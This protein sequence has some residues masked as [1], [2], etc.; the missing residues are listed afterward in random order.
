MA[1]FIS[2]NIAGVASRHFAACA[3]V[4][5]YAVGVEALREGY[6]GYFAVGGHADS[7]RGAV[8]RAGVDN[9]Q[10]GY[11]LAP[12]LYHRGVESCNITLP[13]LYGIMLRIG[14]WGLFITFVV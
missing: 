10:Q 5:E 1:D 12:Y 13:L 4:L 6:G 2:A 14:K 9:F 8:Q 3:V 7:K 11:A